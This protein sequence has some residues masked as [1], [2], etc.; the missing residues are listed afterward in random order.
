MPAEHPINRGA[1]GA[2]FQHGLRGYM[3]H[4]CDGKGHEWPQVLGASAL[5][6]AGGSEKA[7]IFSSFLL[8]TL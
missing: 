2:A 1:Q 4:V 6:A 5:G 3:R 8:N 7:G